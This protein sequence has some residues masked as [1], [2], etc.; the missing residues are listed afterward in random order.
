VLGLALAGASAWRLLRRPDPSAA[1]P[2][3]ALLLTSLAVPAAVQTALTSKSPI[4]A[5]VLVG[6]LLGLALVVIAR[7]AGGGP[8][9][10]AQSRM[11]FAAGTLA[12][13]FVLF[14][15]GAYFL[16]ARPLTS[17]RE[18][19][20]DEQRLHDRIAQVSR[21]RGMDPVF[22]AVDHVSQ[23]LASGTVK[24]SLYERTGLW[25]DARPRSGYANGPIARDEAVGLVRH[26]DFVVLTRAPDHV[27][28]LQPFDLD[29]ER[30]RPELA[31]LCG[32]EL[33]ALGTFRSL[34]RE[35]D[36]YARA[37]RP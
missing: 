20:L 18:A 37:A 31:A 3:L 35:V 11:L 10:Q 25:L 9:S 27:P 5:N 29:L 26:S 17:S 28:S 8:V 13:A 14:R 7:V 4:V 22:I 2:P 6:P 30:L 15:Q 16:T 1:E 34:G 12:L 33:E 32:R 19:L 36:L 24:A 21:E 23:G